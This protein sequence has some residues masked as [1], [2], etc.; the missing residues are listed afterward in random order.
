MATSRRSTGRRRKGSTS[1]AAASPASPSLWPASAEEPQTSATSGLRCYE[2]CKWSGRVGLWART[3]LGSGITWGPFALIWRPKVT[4][5]YRLSFRLRLLARRTSGTDSS[6]WRT[7]TNRVIEPK[8]S[9]KKLSGRKAT[10]PQV[11][12][13][14]QVAAAERGLWPTP[15]ASERG[16]YQR[17]RGDPLKPRPTL[18]GAVKMFPTP[19]AASATGGQ[20]SRGGDRKDELLLGGIARMWPTQKSTPSGPDFARADRPESGGDDLATAVARDLLP[21]PA[22][23]DRRS[24]QGTDN[25]G[26]APQL[27]EVAGGQLN[28]TW[29][30]WLMGFPLGWTDLGPS[31]T[32]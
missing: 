10:D 9:V 26:H 2:L 14:D 29:V 19:S 24:G 32:P 17:D 28:P 4:K 11:G 12:L 30:E 22:A 15:R 20:T 13:A 25:A 23:R 3:F 31:E 18:T 16:D 1:S 7:P 21:T 6:S 27:P 8:S 5:S